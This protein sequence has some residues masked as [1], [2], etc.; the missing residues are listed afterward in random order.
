MPVIQNYLSR[1]PAELKPVAEAVKAEIE[2]R[3]LWPFLK[4]ASTDQSSASESVF[5]SRNGR[6][7]I[8]SPD[9]Q[10]IA[11]VETGWGRPGGSGGFGA[12]NSI[13]IA[14]V[15]GT[16]GQN[17]RVVSDMY[18][19]SWMSDSKRVGTARDAFVA[20]SDFD[21]N[22]LAEFGEMLAERYRRTYNPGADWTKLDLRSQFGASMPH[23]KRLEGTEDFGWGAGGAFSPDGRFYGPVRDGKG[24]FF[25][26]VDDQRLPI[27]LALSSR[28]YGAT[29]SPDGRYVQVSND[30][31][32]LII[33][34]QTLSSHQI[35]NVDDDYFPGSS[36]PWSRDGKRL[37]FL[38]DGQVWV[39]DTH[40]NG[41]KQLTFDSTR[42]ACP[43]FSRD[44]RSVAYLTWQPDNRRHYERVGPTDLWVVDVASTLATRVTASAPGRINGFDW[45]D[46][47]TLII[48]RLDE[49]KDFFAPASS[50]RRISLSTAFSK[51]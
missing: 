5:P 51:N 32:W 15:V 28:I 46:D 24:S 45:L 30:T 18:L 38:R 29:W 37:V 14:H 23:Q 33:D 12:S 36:S 21:G 42:K 41:A 7:P 43:T 49:K 2:T 20:I 4:T 10:W 11:Y 34:M 40:G 25:L 35:A 48:D 17:D 8:T 27:K 6:T 50:L 39:S 26:G 31:E 44:G 1:A 3:S 16:N 22:V 9:G 19:K 13:G 47:Y